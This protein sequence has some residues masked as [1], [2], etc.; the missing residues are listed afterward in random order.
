MSA[1]RKATG[2]PARVVVVG[3]G[4]W[5]T[6]MAV[7]LAGREPVVLLGRRPDKVARLHS[8]RQNADNLPGIIFPADLTVT[9]DVRA[10]READFVVFAV[11]SAHLRD[12]AAR[13]ASRLSGTADVLSLVKGLEGG[14][15]MRMS[16]VI[17][18]AT[19][20]DVGR[21][22]ALSGPNLA[23]EIA[24][25][26]PAS[27]VVGAQDQDLARRIQARVGTRSFRVYVNSDIVGVELCGALKNIVA[28]AAG[29][30][31]GL[32]FGD[33]GKAGL[34]TRGLAEMIRLGLAAGANP[35]TFAGLAGIGDV[36]AT[37]A[38]GLSR[39]HRLG[40]ELAKGPALGRHRGDPAGRRGGRL[41]GR[42]GPGAG[43]PAGRRPADR[44]RGPAGPVRGQE[45]P[46][47]PHRPAGARV[48][49]RAG[50]PAVLARSGRRG[51]GFS[52]GGG[53]RR[54]GAGRLSGS[55]TGRIADRRARRVAVDRGARLRPS[56][57]VAQPG[58]APEWGSG[59]RAFESL[60][61]D[62]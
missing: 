14:T 2:R 15:L 53:V 46:A 19:G 40:V 21:V 43:R 44:P 37:C 59:G 4:A 38:S 8:D 57:G 7:L 17:S 60:R 30:A 9:A 18:Q 54:P 29:A 20:I 16:E 22:A 12:A 55:P 56:R 51:P 28:I 31:D 36:I 34:I 61:P 49:G 10:I 13:I 33:N 23:A 41:H 45:R 25:G 48:Q 5:G 62:H 32:G 24:R 11:P 42:R 26:L 39:N 58:S 6:T 50:R 47:L 52:D 27:A 1:A 3:T 35:L